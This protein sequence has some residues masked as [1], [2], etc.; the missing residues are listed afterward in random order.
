[1]A[2]LGPNTQAGFCTF[3]SV[4]FDDTPYV[5]LAADTSCI[6]FVLNNKTG[7]EVLVTRGGTGDAYI[8]DDND[9]ITL[10]GDPSDYSVKNNTDAASVSIVF[11]KYKYK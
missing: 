9:T 5:A 1:M 2:S 11:C 7:K 3:D 8:L 6:F 4:T 10:Y